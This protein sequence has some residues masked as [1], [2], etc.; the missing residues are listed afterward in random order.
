MKFNC[1]LKR[2]VDDSYDIEIGRKLQDTLVSDFKGGL[3]GKTKKFAIVTDSIV[4]D[5]YG[6]DI[7]DR[8]NAA[9]LKA[10]L[11]VIPEGEKSKTRQM[12]EFVEDSMLEKGFRRDCCVVAV[13]GGV[14]TDLAGFVAGTFGRGVPFVNY[15]TTLLAAA[16]ASVG[17]KTAVD[18]PL[19][20]NLIGLFNQPKKVYLDI[21]TWKTLPEKQLSSGLSETIKHGCLGDKELF[22]YLEK[23]V[24]KVLECDGEACEYI[25]K[26]NCE[27]KYKVVMKDE[28]ESG[29]REV[30]N[31]G[32]TVGRAIETVSDYRLYHG[33]AVA[34]G[35]VAQSRLGEKLGFISHEN[36]QRVEKLLERA[37]LPQFRRDWPN[38]ISYIQRISPSEYGQIPPLS[39]VG[40]YTVKGERGSRNT[41][42]E[43]ALR[44]LARIDFIQDL[45]IIPGQQVSFRFRD[46]NTRA[47]LRDVGSALEL[48]AYKACVD[49]A[50]FHDVISSA[51]V[52]WDE[53]LGH[54][55]VSNEIDVMAARG[56]IPLFLSCKACDIKTEALNELAILRDRF[57][58][59]GAKA[60]IVT[61][62]VCNAAARHRAAQLGIAVIDLEELKTGQLVHRLKVIMKAE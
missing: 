19:A 15:A 37:K 25:A 17:G 13:G 33:E 26:K 56:V 42:N 23:N 18:T 35:M 39:V 5:L 40:G 31:L 24:E 61:T 54:G 57:G 49:S 4:V 29:L 44:E 30:L 7:Y 10:E 53:V 34:I 59:K 41:A 16:D 14:V 9:G 43:A 8:L 46:L 58:G 21:D 45:E 52:R 36:E 2:V 12:K 11:F 28:R 38:I 60:A 51:V 32:H 1:E 6:R 55:S 3:V 20:T 48:Y 27:V 22:E 50:I 62:E 47:W